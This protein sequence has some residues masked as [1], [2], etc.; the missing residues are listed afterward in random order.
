MQI[1][2]LTQITLVRPAPSLEL[3]SNSDVQAYFADLNW[4]C[5]SF[6]RTTL[7]SSKKEE[8]NGRKI[9]PWTKTIH[10]SKEIKSSTS[11]LRAFPR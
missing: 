6:H 7:H 8:K 11:S 10:V 9:P 4:S 2:Y 1:E 3:S 5:I